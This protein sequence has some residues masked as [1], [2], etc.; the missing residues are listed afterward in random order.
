M[1]WANARQA[2][3]KRPDQF[4]PKE[5]ACVLQLWHRRT[6]GSVPG[7]RGRNGV[8]FDIDA[9]A[10][11]TLQLSVSPRVARPPKGNH[12]PLDNFLRRRYKEA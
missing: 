6:H 3:L 12:D 2:Y 1:P 4:S 11:D 8:A 9:H 5:A 10:S 7:P